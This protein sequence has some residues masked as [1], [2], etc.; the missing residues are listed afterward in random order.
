[1]L[2]LTVWNFAMA[3]SRTSCLA[4][5]VNKASSVCCEGRCKTE[6][7]FLN[8][9]TE[10]WRPSACQDFGASLAYTL[11]GLKRMENADRQK[12]AHVSW[13]FQ[14]HRVEFFLLQQIGAGLV[15]LKAFAA[16]VTVWRGIRDNVPV[17]S[18]PVQTDFRARQGP[19]SLE[20]KR[21][22]ARPNR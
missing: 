13:L 6:L 9:L 15:L 11:A 14:Q 17:A 19:A 5:K 21:R 20:I 8:G 18:R 7:V 4:E 2:G 22:R 12:P 3:P 1:M 10:G 16:V